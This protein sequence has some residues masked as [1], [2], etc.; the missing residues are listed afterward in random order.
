MNYIV[1]DDMVVKVNDITN[2]SCDTE[3]CTVK[4]SGLTSTC[5]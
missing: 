1:I 3:K 4:Y 5:T 2:V